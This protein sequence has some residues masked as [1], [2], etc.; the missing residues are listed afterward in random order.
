MKKL[1]V[2]LMAVLFLLPLN[3]NVCALES[4]SQNLH[5]NSPS[6]VCADDRYV[7]VGDNTDK[8]GIL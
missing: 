4:V 6:A 7:Y 1:C 2:L 8:G 3:I 5:F